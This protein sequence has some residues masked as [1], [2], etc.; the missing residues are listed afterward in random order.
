LQAKPGCIKFDLFLSLEDSLTSI[1]WDAPRDID[2]DKKATIL[3]T[4][5]QDI[6]QE[7]PDP[8]MNDPYWFGLKL[9]KFARLALIADSLG[10][11]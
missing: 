11:E 8:D 7:Y 3:E 1:E 10:Q 9:A 4:L 5:K 2:A 6:Q